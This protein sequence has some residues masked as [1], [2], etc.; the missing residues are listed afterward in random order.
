MMNSG[1]KSEI[2]VTEFKSYLTS[3]K[4]VLDAIK[5]DR[6]LKKQKKIVI[7]PNLTDTLF[8]PVTTDVNCIK[9]IIEYIQSC[10]PRAKII[11]AEG[12]G[13]CDT[14][15]AFERLGYVALEDVYGI[16]LVDLN[17]DER[18]TLK[19]SKAMVLKELEVPKT[20]LGAYVISVPVPKEHGMARFTG[21][22]KN[23]IGIYLPKPT[24]REKAKSLA[25]RVIR[26][27]MPV[28][29]PPVWSKSRLHLLGLNKGI[30]DLNLY[31]H[32]DLA[33]VDAKIGQK[34]CEIYGN[35]CKPP[36]NRIYAGYDAVAIDSYSAGLLRVDWKRVGHLKYANG[37][38]GNADPDKMSVRL[39]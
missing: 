17:A 1:A 4:K 28:L 34:E 26:A 15:K 11:V 25:G 5:A 14:P 36:L 31:V 3:V 29:T 18:K 6:Q 37:I 2:A 32:I 39:I 8:P 35:P 19:N 13:G 38:L 9:A 20:L 30:F 23:M 24:L 10:S 21:A 12:S 27:A 16:K 33:V 22:M 7:K